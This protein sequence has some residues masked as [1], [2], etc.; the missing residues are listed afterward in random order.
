MIWA[1]LIAAAVVPIGLAAASPLLQW[2]EPAYVAAGLAGVVAL[3]LLL[4]QPL[5]AA[6]VLP[7]IGVARGRRLH[8]WT[9][10]FLVLGVVVHVAGLW[11]TSPPDVIDALLFVSPTPFAPWG[12]IAMWAI[13]ATATLAALRHPLRLRWRTWRFAHVSLALVIVLGSAIHAL[14]IDGTMEVVSK[15]ALCALVILAVLN[16]MVGDRSRR[17]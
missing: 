17:R 1:A 11:I 9:G 5:L 3:V 4:V 2:R 8:R 10:G 15:A 7:G 14:L 16:A 12:V 13:F 6:G